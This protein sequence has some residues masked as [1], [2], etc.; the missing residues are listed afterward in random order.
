MSRHALLLALSAA[1]MPGLVSA[2][3]T[4]VYKSKGASGETVYSQIETEDAEAHRV[5]T[6]EPEAP[7][8]AAQAPAKSPAEQACD[9]AK[10][11]YELLASDKRVQF[12]RDGDGTPEEMSAEERASNTDMAKRQVDAYCTPAAE[13]Q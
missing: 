11:N 1:L 2:E 5:G 12:D 3:D 10:A 4:T 6:S 13:G 8:A 9:R 7:P